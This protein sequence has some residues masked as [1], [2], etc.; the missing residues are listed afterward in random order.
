MDRVISFKVS[1][2]GLK[3]S[4]NELTK[5]LVTQ[6]KPGRGAADIVVTTWMQSLY[7]IQ[8]FRYAVVPIHSTSLVGVKSHDI[9]SS[10]TSGRVLWHQD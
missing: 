9:L 1:R 7:P 3:G 8:N 5:K 4:T 10:T 2:E 6:S